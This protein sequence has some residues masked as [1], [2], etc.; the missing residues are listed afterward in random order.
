MYRVDLEIAPIERAVLVVMINL[1][2]ALRILGALDCER[3]ATGW[4]KFAA[5]VLL[6]SGQRMPLVELGIMSGLRF[7]SSAHHQRRL[8]V[9][10]HWRLPG[11]CVPGMH[12]HD[13]SYEQCTGGQCRHAPHARGRSVSSYAAEGSPGGLAEATEN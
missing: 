2:L 3:N 13:C 6:I 10:P 12:R 1:A 4:S 9:N 7:R 5:G 11:E 8:K